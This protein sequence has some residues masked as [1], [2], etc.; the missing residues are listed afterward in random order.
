[1]HSTSKFAANHLHERITW[2]WQ[3]SS[4]FFSCFVFIFFS[5]TRIEW[6]RAEMQN[7]KNAKQ[8]S[9]IMIISVECCV[10]TTTTIVKQ[11]KQVNRREKTLELVHLILCRY[12]LRSLALSRS[13]LQLQSR[14][15]RRQARARVHYPII[16]M[17][18]R[19]FLIFGQESLSL[20]IALF[21][22]LAI[23]L[24]LISSSA[25]AYPLRST[26]SSRHTHVP[27]HVFTSIRSA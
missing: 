15:M 5:F 6:L 14:V 10:L 22:S 17:Q 7:C 21:I 25:R 19:H 9:I 16:C 20:W 13:H 12:L 24:M 11:Q 3:F 27:F 8:Y 4:Y 2:K 23:S 18:F 1:M 26:I